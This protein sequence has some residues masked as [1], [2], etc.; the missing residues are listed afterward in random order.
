MIILAS[1]SPRRKELLGK[2]TSNFKI[3]PSTC[4]ETIPDN[5]KAIDVAEYLSAQKAKDI[6]KDNKDDVVIGS[7]TTI[8]FNNKVYG[9]AKDKNDARNMLKEFSGNTHY[10]VTGVTI[11]SSKRSISF[12]SISEVTF[13]ELSDKDIDD[14]LSI[15]E[16]V[17]KAGAYAIQG[18]ASLWI[19]SIDGDYFNVVGLPVHRLYRLYFEIFGENIF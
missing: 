7:D 15:D 4:D 19:N 11:I 9:K 5:I 3:I 6:F 16:Y 18:Y 13:F 8:V 17:D 2:I 14:Y 1:A 12:S 10:V